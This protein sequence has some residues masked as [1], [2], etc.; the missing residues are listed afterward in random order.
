MYTYP[1]K[2]KKQEVHGPLEKPVQIKKLT[3][4]IQWFYHTVNLD[5][6]HSILS[7]F[8]KTNPTKNV[9]RFW[10]RLFISSMY[11]SMYFRYLAVASILKGSRLFMWI[12]LDSLHPKML[13]TKFCWNWLS[14]YGEKYIVLISS[15]YVFFN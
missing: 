12:N 5:R 6:T 14:G 4:I 9:Q 2:K 13:C 7:I 11:L 1:I 15:M 3:Y 8:K 10:G